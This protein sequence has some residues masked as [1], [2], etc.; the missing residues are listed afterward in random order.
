PADERNG[1]LV[2]AY[3]RLL[4]S[5]D[6]GVRERAAYDWCR[7]EDAVVAGADA[8]PSAVGFASPRYEDPRFRM[9]FARI[10]THYF[11][12]G[13]WLADGALLRSADRLAGIPGVLIHGRHDLGTPLVVAYELHR[14]WP[15]SELV[16]VG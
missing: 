3:Y 15:G 5:P 9:A 11:H 4:Q 8:A 7:W 6:A 16:I 10:V 1:D 2:A 12:H 13:A 14:A